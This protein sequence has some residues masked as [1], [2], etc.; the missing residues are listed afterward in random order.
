MTLIVI[1]LAGPL[2][3][4]GQSATYQYRYDLNGDGRIDVTDLMLVSSHWGARED[5]GTPLKVLNNWNFYQD[6]WGDPAI[7]GEVKNTSDLFLK[8][9]YGFVRVYDSEGNLV[10]SKITSDIYNDFSLNPGE[11]NCFVVWFDEGIGDPSTIEI[12]FEAREMAT[13]NPEYQVTDPVVVYDSHYDILAGTVTNLE[14]DYI[15]LQDIR[16]TVYRESDGKV[17]A[18]GQDWLDAP[19]AIA[20]GESWE[21]S[22]EEGGIVSSGAV[23]P[24]DPS[25]WSYTVKFSDARHN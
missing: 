3:A 2:P 24:D 8:G 11:V 23:P 18:C 4:G 17:L 15:A 14:D 10:A 6:S 25:G 1:L 16:Y 7:A 20:P 21:F 5:E 13:R 19:H 9:I 22:L 12:E